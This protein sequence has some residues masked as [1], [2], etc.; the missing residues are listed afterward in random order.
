MQV[1]AMLANS[2]SPSDRKHSLHNRV[3]CY[4]TIID[5]K[6]THVIKRLNERT[7]TLNINALASSILAGGVE[8]DNEVAE[9]VGDKE[10]QKE[11]DNE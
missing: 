3:I 6:V 9:Y 4:A 11:A 2:E 8:S 5:T 10:E 7:Q 1:V